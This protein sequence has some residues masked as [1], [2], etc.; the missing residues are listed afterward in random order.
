M[1]LSAKS[2]WGYSD[3]VWTVTDATAGQV[4]LPSENL[5]KV[6]RGFYKIAATSTRMCMMRHDVA[7]FA[8][9]T[10]AHS[11][12]T[13]RDKSNGA[14]L[15]SAQGTN[16]LLTNTWKSITAGGVWGAYAWHRWGW[17]HGTSSHGGAR[18]G[19][20]ADN[21]ASDSIDAALGFGLHAAESPSIATGSGYYHY[22]WNPVPSPPA[23]SLQ[24]QIWVR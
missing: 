15:G 11:A 21:D 18:L 2:P 17:H 1:R 4:P 19:F 10:I 6:S 7:A 12:G 8:C 24:G 9:E 14:A 23:A 13:A 5:D 3:K 22:P 16:N 20:S